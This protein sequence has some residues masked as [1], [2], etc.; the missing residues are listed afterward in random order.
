MMSHVRDG[1]TDTIHVN[2]LI[3]SCVQEFVPT[4]FGMSHDPHVLGSF[5]M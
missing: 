4:N 1:Q 5:I 2:V 3:S